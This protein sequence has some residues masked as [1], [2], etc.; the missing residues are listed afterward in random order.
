MKALSIR[1]PWAW[2]IVH[3]YK[4]I[5][6]R[7]WNTK[8]RGMFYV[9]ASLKLDGDAAERTRIRALAR[10]WYDIDV[11]T[12]DELEQLTGG[13]V[14]RAN[15]VDVVEHSTSPWFKGPFGFVLDTNSANPMRFRPYT[16]R[17]SFFDVSI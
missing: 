14:G 2:L 3:G 17:L 13:I 5:E 6:N 16:G 9:H 12:D 10:E 15:L 11:P 7:S 8:F 4:D 1:Q